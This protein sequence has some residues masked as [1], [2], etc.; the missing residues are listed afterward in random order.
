MGPG[1]SGKDCRPQPLLTPAWLVMFGVCVTHSLSLPS[2]APPGP[3]GSHALVTQ[4]LPVWNLGECKASGLVFSMEQMGLIKGANEFQA[5]HD[6]T[7][8]AGGQARQAPLP[9]KTAD[10]AP[11]A[12]CPGG[13]SQST[14]S[15]P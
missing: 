11:P 2:Q 7:G 13:H 4:L 10:T 3:Q 14:G 15:S 12:T 5:L 9:G 8:R 6:C 1:H